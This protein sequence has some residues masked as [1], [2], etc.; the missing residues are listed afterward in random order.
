MIPAPT[1]GHVSSMGTSIRIVSPA[2]YTEPL[3]LP[4]ASEP[5]VHKAQPKWPVALPLLDARW[6]RPLVPAVVH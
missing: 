6:Q 1:N 5:S 3:Q 4:A 2:N